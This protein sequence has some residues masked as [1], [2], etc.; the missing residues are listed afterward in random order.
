MKHKSSLFALIL[1]IHTLI[2]G[3]VTVPFQVGEIL[4]Y[5]SNFNLIKAGTARLHVSALELIDGV[6][7]YHIIFT[8][9]TN[10]IL[11]RIYKVRD[12]VE[13]WIDANG[14]FTRKFSKK[15]REGQYR[16]N[17]SA[18]INYQDSVVTTGEDSFRIN[19]ELR[20]PYS[21][22]YY[23]RTIPLNVG[24]RFTYVTFD[25]NQFINI[26]LIVHRKEKISVKAGQFDCL[27]I[28]PF[29]KGRSLF[30]QQGDMTIWLSDDH[31]RLPVKIVSK[32]KFG[33]MTLKLRNLGD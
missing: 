33:S 2:A 20:D 11:D 15:V 19:D 16:H 32:T 29:R 12:R 26:H 14:L 6:P 13:T 17:F 5:D 18:I 9:K 28:K 30:K 10:K 3:Q 21:L 4:N 1:F 27:V 25:N 7:V 8:V 24:D 22:F 31:Q 23:L